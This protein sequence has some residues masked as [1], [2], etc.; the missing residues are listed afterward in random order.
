MTT[1]QEKLIDRMNQKKLAA[2]IGEMAM[3]RATTADAAMTMAGEPWTFSKVLTFGKDLSAHIAMA[4]PELL[5]ECTEG[6]TL[7]G[8]TKAQYDAAIDQASRNFDEQVR[9]VFGTSICG[10]EAGDSL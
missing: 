7:A 6:K 10:V 5:A 4:M 2:L 3:H 8:T 1:K 9:Q